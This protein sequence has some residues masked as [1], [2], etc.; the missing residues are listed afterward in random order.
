V[1]SYGIAFKVD[2][3]I[4]DLTFNKDDREIILS[5]SDRLTINLWALYSVFEKAVDH[6]RDVLNSNPE[7]RLHFE[8]MFADYGR[9][10]ISVTP[11][12]D[13]A[14]VRRRP[15][16][17]IGFANALQPPPGSSTAHRGR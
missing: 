10:D 16:P 13:T 4:V 5:K 6:Y 14:Y 9:I 7:L 2:G 11:P 1:H 3:C 15:D 12:A 17:G 8:T